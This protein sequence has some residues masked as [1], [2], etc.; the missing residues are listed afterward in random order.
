MNLL[1]V[2]QD[3]PPRLG[4]IQTYAQA[5]ARQ[6]AREHR[7]TVIAP[8]HRGASACDRNEP[9]RTFRYPVFH[10]SWFGLTTPVSI[11]LIALRQG[12]GITLHTQWNTAIGS[13]VAWRLG[14]ISRYY[15]AAHGR[16]LLHDNLG[17]ISRR[18]RRLTL[19]GAAAVFAVSRFTGGL[20]SQLGVAGERIQV[21]ANG[22]DLQLFS[23]RPR[24]EARRLLGVFAP[25]MLLAVGRLV[26]RKGFDTAIQAFTAI[27]A[28]HP[29]TVLVI[30]GEG[31]DKER[32]HCL[33]GPLCRAGRILFRGEATALE[34]A[35]YYSLADVLVMPSR[36]EKDGSV[37]GFG[38]VF[39]EANACGTPVIGSW[40]GGIPDAV[41]HGIN[42]LLV[43]PNAVDELAMAL[44]RLL[45]D[46]DLLL[47]LA[48]GGL[49]RAASFT[50]ERAAR[51]MQDR[52]E[53]DDL[54]GQH[55]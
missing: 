19:D 4:G 31:P 25:R 44:E 52:I 24:E 8:A 29:D 30:V 43:Q 40:C 36:D 35:H 33:A 38:L 2:A 17:T 10:T 42:G 32:L 49:E 14:L 20:L 18:L 37:E 23:P 5:L 34:L 53:S 45:S 7:I 13:W 48:T 15:V 41:E 1:I 47:R 12:T 28:R 16:E 54:R 26:P 11:P 51:A 27:A 39:L 21:V 55:R 22:V 9:Y 46:G 3:F 6:L 50:W